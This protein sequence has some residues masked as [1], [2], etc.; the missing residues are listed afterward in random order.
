MTAPEP[1]SE[2]RPADHRVKL[3]VVL[4][5]AGWLMMVTAVWVSEGLKDA[6]VTGLG[7]AAMAAGV[8]AFFILM[9]TAEDM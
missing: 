6:V 7:A 3:I 2:P 8:A 4:A 9:A 1:L 5:A